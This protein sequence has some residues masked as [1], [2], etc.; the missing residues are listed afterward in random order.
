MPAWS[1]IAIGGGIFLMMVFLL[2]VQKSRKPVSM[3]IVH[4]VIG[5]GAMLL[6]NLFS[7]FT[8]T[9]IPV[10]PL[11]LSVSGVLGIPGVTTLL[12]LQCFFRPL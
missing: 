11:S 3:A 8:Q 1:I 2:K 6:V 10:S 12:L 4:I 5:I 7:G 9:S